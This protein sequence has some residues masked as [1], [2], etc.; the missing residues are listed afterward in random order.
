MAIENQN[1]VEAPDSNDITNSHESVSALINWVKKILW[2]DKINWILE[3]L[4][5]LPFWIGDKIAEYIDA[6]R[7][8]RAELANEVEWNSN[9]LDGLSIAPEEFQDYISKYAREFNTPVSRI[10]WIINLENRDWKSNIYTWWSTKK[11]ESASAFWF[12]QATEA[13]WDTERKVVNN[14][15]QLDIGN[16]WED[17][18]EMQ[19]AFVASHLRTIK[20]QMNCSWLEAMTYYHTWVGIKGIPASKAQ[21]FAINH[22]MIANRI[23]WV[24]VKDK[25]IITW[26][27]FIT[28]ESY[29]KASKEHYGQIT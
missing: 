3:S 10:I 20:D 11:P 7:E 4:K 15:I 24:E 12:W 14:K 23:P 26:A 13:T 22:A 1:H 18:P 25:K 19:I 9:L 29:F 8:G 5:W 28:W 27:D 6:S 16:H 17:N 21:E 2:E